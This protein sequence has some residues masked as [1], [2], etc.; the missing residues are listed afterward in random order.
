M[1]LP[2]E[3]DPFFRDLQKRAQEKQLNR[4][5]ELAAMAKLERRVH[6]MRRLLHLA[7]HGTPE[8]PVS[9]RR[10]E[11]ILIDSRR[12]A[13][14]ILRLARAWRICVGRNALQDK[15]LPDEGLGYEAAERIFV[16][17]V[18]GSTEQ[19]IAR[20]LEA[21]RASLGEYEGDIFPVVPLRDS[22]QPLAGFFRQL[23]RYHNGYEWSPPTGVRRREA[24]PSPAVQL[25]APPSFPRT[26]GEAQDWMVTRVDLDRYL[27]RYLGRDRCRWNAADLKPHLPTPVWSAHRRWPWFR[28]GDLIAVLSRSSMNDLSVHAVTPWLQKRLKAPGSKPEWA[29]KATVRPGPP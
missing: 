19:E 8:H 23:A 25:P 28:L 12:W 15:P 20:A 24:T 10:E 5:R 11:K 1:T 3:Q 13:L 9:D 6:R 2:P 22:Q 14:H 18:N 16:T 26:L 29:A 4:Q 21:A 17:A 27:D 7:A